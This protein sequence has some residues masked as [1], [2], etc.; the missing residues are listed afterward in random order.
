MQLIGQTP[1]DIKLA[2]NARRQNLLSKLAALPKPKDIELE[3]DVPEEQQ[4]PTQIEMSEE[5]A[6][7][8]DAREKMRRDAAELAEF[9][10]Q[11][12]VMQ[13][14]LPR[15]T[16][17]DIDAMLKNAHD[18]PDLIQREVAM[19]TALLITNDALK[20]GG[21]KVTGASRPL[22]IFDEGALQNARLLVAE[23]L[24]SDQ[25]RKE[26]EN[27]SRAWEEL[28]G[29]VKLPGLDG[30]YEDEIDEHQM[31]VETFDNIQ[32]KIMESAERGNDLEKK[33]AKLHG[34]YQQR[35]K[36][37]RQK[38][39]DVADALEKTRIDLN[40]SRNAQVGEDAAV[41]RRLEG[42]RDE[43]AFV[44][45]RERLAQEEYAKVRDELND[46]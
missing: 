43:V 37:L 15:P 8:L 17:I 36:I 3:L 39:M 45:R 12:K 19:E 31:M 25:A 20:F 33:L 4:E 44:S 29:A 40:T 34:G 24:S 7:I 9:N 27:F 16:V 18:M 5:D 42:L 22:R 1:R 11:T 2:E 14:R 6:A 26:K 10:R 41:S 13:L 28:H 38:I 23:E 35:A 46:L 21:A 32:D 30:Y